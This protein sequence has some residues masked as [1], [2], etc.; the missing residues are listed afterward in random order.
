MRHGHG[1]MVWA[2]G[3]KYVGIFSYN[4]PSV[5]GAFYFPNGDKYEGC[6]S[7]NRIN[8]YGIYFHES[9]GIKLIGNWRN[10]VMHGLGREEWPKDEGVYIG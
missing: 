1:E 4:E 3:A 6:W 10:D 9:S 7:S 8:G 2:D 5:R